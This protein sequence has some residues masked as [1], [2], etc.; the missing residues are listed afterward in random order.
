MYSKDNSSKALEYFE[1]AL[2]SYKQLYGEIHKDV[3]DS[4]NK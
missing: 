2:Q 3:A 4:I 1:K